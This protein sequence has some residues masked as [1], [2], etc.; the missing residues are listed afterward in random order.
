MNK[1]SQIKEIS[2]TLG[3]DTVNYNRNIK[4]ILFQN[5]VRN[6]NPGKDKY[7]AIIYPVTDL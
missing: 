2:K 3:F 1:K 5:A 7:L 6:S 4:M